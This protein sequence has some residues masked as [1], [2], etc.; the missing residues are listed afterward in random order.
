MNC[1]PGLERVP[2]RHLG[3]AADKWDP[4]LHGIEHHCVVLNAITRLR[5]YSTDGVMDL[6][7]KESPSSTSTD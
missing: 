2:G 7:S 1:R 6:K 4:A 5:L 3:N